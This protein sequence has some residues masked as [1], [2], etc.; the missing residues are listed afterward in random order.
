MY[1]MFYNICYNIYIFQ[2][3]FN[4][5]PGND[6]QKKI[7]PRTIFSAIDHPMLRPVP[8]TALLWS[9]IALPYCHGHSFQP[10]QHQERVHNLRVCGQRRGSHQHKPRHRAAHKFAAGKRH[11]W[12]WQLLPL[13]KDKGHLW[14]W[15][16]TI[17]PTRSLM[18]LVPIWSS[19]ACLEASAI[20][21]WHP[22]PAAAAYRLQCSLLNGA[23]AAAAKARVALCR[24]NDHHANQNTHHA[25]LRHPWAGSA[26][27]NVQNMTIGALHSFTAWATPKQQPHQI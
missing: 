1:Y 23:I 26:I 13:C 20:I 25:S 15:L 14:L 9:T 17:V 22:W 6:F 3:S 27:Q 4:L 8:I 18:I 11:N 24:E 19:M 5:L 10:H 12:L 2:N 21:P 16:S 7:N